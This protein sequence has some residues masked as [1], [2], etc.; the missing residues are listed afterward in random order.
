MPYQLRYVHAA[1]N[2]VPIQICHEGIAGS[3]P[4][5]EVFGEI[6]DDWVLFGTAAA[7]YSLYFRIP[8]TRETVVV[9]GGNSERE[10]SELAASFV[11]AAEQVEDFDADVDPQET[12]ARELN[13]NEFMRETDV[14]AILANR[15]F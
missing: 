3:L 5:T 11:R 14:C 10:N 9:E 13:L 7:N 1:P 15:S 4:T 8:V 2:S 12:T 6:L